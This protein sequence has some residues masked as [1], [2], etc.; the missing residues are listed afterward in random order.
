MQVQYLY[1]EVMIHLVNFV[2][3]KAAQYLEIKRLGDL[4]SDR[5]AK[6]IRGNTAERNRQMFGAE[7]MN[8]LESGLNKMA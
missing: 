7:A 2:G 8:I 5:I 1:L 3:F 6:I 4:A